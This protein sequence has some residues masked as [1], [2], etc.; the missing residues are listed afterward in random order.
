MSIHSGPCFALK[1]YGKIFFLGHPNADGT[2][3]TLERLVMG[4]NPASSETQVEGGGEVEQEEGRGEG[5]DENEAR[6]DTQLQEQGSQAQDYTP[7]QEQEGAGHSDQLGNRARLSP[8]A[9]LSHPPPTLK[10]CVRF[11]SL[12]YNIDTILSEEGGQFSKN[13]WYDL[14]K[15]L[16]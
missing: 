13:F 3:A 1:K 14:Q 2:R 7:I 16:L 15:K 8:R 6:D 5:Q 9:S 11:T 12:P 4:N 10:N